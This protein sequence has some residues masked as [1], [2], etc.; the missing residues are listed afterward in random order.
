MRREIDSN[1]REAWGEKGKVPF[2][3]RERK[4]TLERIFCDR[5]FSSVVHRDLLLAVDR[6]AIVVIVV[7][8][9]S[10]RR[11]RGRGGRGGLLARPVMALPVLVLAKLPA[12]SGHV[13]AAASLG[14][15]PAAIPARSLIVFLLKRARLELGVSPFW[16]CWPPRPCWSATWWPAAW[17]SKASRRVSQRPSPPAAA[18]SWPRA[19]PGKVML[20]ASF[21]S[22]QLP[23]LPLAQPLQPSCAPRRSSPRCF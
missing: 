11:R 1:E 17:N 14:R 13:A 15:R 5:F 4:V 8:F 19:S 9:R 22:L 18:P 7:G 20:E 3:K 10:P 2:I 6:V 23:F 21:L 16:T 12:V